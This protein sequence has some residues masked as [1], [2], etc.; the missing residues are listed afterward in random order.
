MNQH[1][2]SFLEEASAKWQDGTAIIHNNKKTSFNELLISSRALAQAL[3]QQV[4]LNGKGIAF[5][6]GNGSKFVSGLFG[7]SYAGAVVMPVLPGTKSIEIENLLRESSIN[8]LLAENGNQIDFKIPFK[9][10]NVSDDFNLYIFQE[11][12]TQIITELFSDAAFI[13]PSSGTTGDS[14]G[15]VIPHKAVDERTAA[16]NEGLKLNSEHKMLW[17]LPMAFHFIVSVILYIRY[18]V[19]IIVADNFLANSI[20]KLANQFKA[21]HLYASPLHY[22]LLA[23]DQSNLQFEK[24]TNAISTSALLESNVSRRFYERFNIRVVQ[25]YGIIEIGLP[26]INTAENSHYDS[27]G[28]SLPAYKVAILDDEM[29]EL[30]PNEQGAFAIKGVGMFSGYLWKL[31]TVE[32][33]LINSWF[34]TGDIAEMDSEGF[35]YIKGRSKSMIN[36]SGNKVFPEEVEAILKLHLYVEDARVYGGTHPLTGELVEAEIILKQ[37][38][39][40]NTESIIALCREHLATYKIP[41]RIFFVDEILRTKTGKISRK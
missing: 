32:E 26:F 37:G 39:E 23:S 33:V 24:L 34:L 18:G 22:R 1:T 35:V 31:K 16:A 13:R 10:I 38:A 4:E 14:K 27:I 17:V 9:E 29:N 5:M 15:V 30:P 8:L 19:T 40:K 28:K 20:L 3:K 21:T 36:V 11:I 2:V 6:C 12:K 7:C 25:A 41:Q